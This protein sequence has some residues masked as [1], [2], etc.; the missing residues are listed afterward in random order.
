MIWLTSISRVCRARET[1]RDAASGV[2]LPSC[3]WARL[4]TE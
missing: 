3:I 2:P 4:Y 1:S